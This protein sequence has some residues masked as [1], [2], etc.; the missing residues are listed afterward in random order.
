MVDV[1]AGDVKDVKPDGLPSRRSSG[2][3]GLV[4]SDNA[5]SPVAMMLILG[6]VAVA[7]VWLYSLSRLG[8][9]GRDIEPVLSPTAV[10]REVPPS[11]FSSDGSAGSSGVDQVEAVGGS[12][13]AHGL[14]AV[15][16]PGGGVGLWGFLQVGPNVLGVPLGLWAGVGLVLGGALVGGGGLLGR[17]WYGWGIRDW[18]PE[19]RA[20]VG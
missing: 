10:A 8:S 14:E 1:A 9:M 15:G 12:S 20:L 2:G 13:R 17:R 19:V 7:G 6:L 18:W 3:G 4:G 5:V 11:P 16:W